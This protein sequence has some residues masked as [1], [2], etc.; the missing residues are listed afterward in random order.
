MLR[1]MKENTRVFFVDLQNH[2]IGI[3]KKKKKKKERK[4]DD[5]ENIS[6]NQLIGKQ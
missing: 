1:K 3:T 5:F 2:N 6:E 4:H